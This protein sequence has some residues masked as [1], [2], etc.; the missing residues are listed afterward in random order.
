MEK[1]KAITGDMAFAPPVSWGL[2]RRGNPPKIKFYGRKK[3]QEE[4]ERFLPWTPHLIESPAAPGLKGNFL[5]APSYWTV[6][7]LGAP[8][9]WRPIF[10]GAP[11][12]WIS[13]CLCARK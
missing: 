9:Y 3:E 11:F 10:L 1:T 6:A 12:Y 8:S 7:F 2:P 13:E 5:C 4:E